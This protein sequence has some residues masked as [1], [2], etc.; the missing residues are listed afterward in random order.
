M[1]I[2][3]DVRNAHDFLAMKDRGGLKKPSKS[4]VTVCLEAEKVLQRL[5]RVSGGKLPQGGGVT[6]A[7]T[8]AV[9]K[10]TQHL[11]LFSD[12]HSHQLDTAVEDNH[13]IILMKQ[14]CSYF[15][16]IRLY[17]LGKEY[18][19]AFSGSK[20]RQRLTKTILFHHQ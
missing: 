19:A 2:T 15:T 17:H 9:L 1:D 5:L 7:V 14:I 16:R 4:T 11:N 12:L 8:T 20:I 13:I 18:T 10:N 3:C 6:E